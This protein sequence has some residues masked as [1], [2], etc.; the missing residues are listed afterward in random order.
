MFSQ[1]FY[2]KLWL[3]F[4]HPS[5]IFSYNEV[6]QLAMHGWLAMYV[7]QDSKWVH[8]GSICI[9]KPRLSKNLSK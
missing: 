6:L 3:L 4:I 8:V 7:V 9:T 1:S 5:G 2:V